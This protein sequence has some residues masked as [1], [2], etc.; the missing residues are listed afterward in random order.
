M[1]DHADAHPTRIV[2]ASPYSWGGA[3]NT[4]GR[5]PPGTEGQLFHTIRHGDGWQ[6]SFGLIEGVVQGGPPAFTSIACAAG[7]SDVLHVVGSVWHGGWL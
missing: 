1:K 2:V 3:L 4:G 5:D 7:P 6:T